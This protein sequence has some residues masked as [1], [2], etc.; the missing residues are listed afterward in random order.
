LS[1]HHA[2][3]LA[4]QIK[5]LPRALHLQFRPRRLDLRKL[6][7]AVNLLLAQLV[8]RV[9]VIPDR[10]SRVLGKSPGLRRRQEPLRH[11]H[12]RAAPVHGLLQRAKL[13]RECLIVGAAPAG[14]ARLVALERARGVREIHRLSPKRVIHGQSARDL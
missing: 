11:P 5:V 12:Q 9:S 2:V 1:L 14:Q 4:E 7:R 10:H 6:H 3:A 8:V 13:A